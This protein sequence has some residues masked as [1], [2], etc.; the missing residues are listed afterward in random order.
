MK[1]S[2]NLKV[3]VILLVIA[4]TV[5]IF[6]ALALADGN[7]LKGKGNSNQG[8]NQSC[9]DCTGSPN[10]GINTGMGNKIYAPDDDGDGIPNGQDSDYVLHECDE[11]CNGTCD[12]VAQGNGWRRNSL[13]NREIAGNLINLNGRELKTMSF[14]KLAQVWGVDANQLL[15]EIKNEFKLIQEYNI[16]NTIDDLRGEYRFSPYQIMEIAERI[17]TAS[18]E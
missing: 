11:E 8:Q 13:E 15:E 9:E 7:G 16:N 4:L 3:G 14:E 17:N 5:G 6:A 1:S 2:R 12:G 10:N 18:V